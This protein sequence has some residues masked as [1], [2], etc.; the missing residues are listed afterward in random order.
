[1]IRC[2]S[3]YNDFSQHPI[4]HGSLISKKVKIKYIQ[5]EFQRQQIHLSN[6][7][8]SLMY[9]YSSPILFWVL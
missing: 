4:A 3:S 1:M 6:A 8:I 7:T 9:A 5:I 2:K